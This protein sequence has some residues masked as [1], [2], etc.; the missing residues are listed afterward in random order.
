MKIGRFFTTTTPV[1]PA[2]V[3]HAAIIGANGK[4]VF[5]QSVAAP[6]S[7]SDAAVAVVAQ[8]YFRGKPGTPEREDSIY[9]LVDRVAREIAEWGHGDDYFDRENAEVFY[10]ELQALLLGQYAAF[11]SPVWFN[12]GVDP[13]PQASACFISHVDD[14]LEAILDEVKTEGVIF[15]KGSGVGTNLSNLRSS[16][17]SLSG[18]GTA[19]GPV[20]FIRGYDAMAGVIKSGG[21]T[22]RSAIM[23]ILNAD[24]PDIEEFVT[25]KAKEGKKQQ[26]L[27]DAGFSAGIDG[28]AFPANEALGHASTQHALE[29]VAECVALTEAT[30]P[31]LGEGRVVG[32]RVF[33]IKAAEPAIRQVQMH[34][35]A[36]TALR[37]DAEAVA[38][39]ADLAG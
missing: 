10:D 12:V 16:K 1:S 29:H 5:E 34:F 39:D 33:E 23:R 15:K 19:S 38:D 37:A 24:H 4:P 2:A 11:N 20:S 8:K 17:E 36:Q 7:W 9:D 32:H 14:N 6:A 27:L 28:E 21:K 3:R 22:R 31:I 13:H 35:L 25:C 18:G 30:M 26:A